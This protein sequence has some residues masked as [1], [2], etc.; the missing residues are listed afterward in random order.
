MFRTLRK[1]RR[2]VAVTAAA[3][4]G[5]TV[6]TAAAARGPAA[7]PGAVTTATV[8][9]VV[10][11]GLVAGQGGQISQTFGIPN[12]LES[13]GSFV[14]V[15]PKRFNAVPHV[16]LGTST[17]PKNGQ[18]AAIQATDVNALAKVPILGDQAALSS[19]S[20]LL[21][22]VGLSGDYSATPSVTHTTTTLDSG[23]TKTAYP[24]DTV[25]TYRLAL[26]GLPVTGQGGKLRVT[27]AGDGSVTELTATPRAVRPAGTVSVISVDAA[28]A[29]CAA[30]YGP[31]V[32]QD[33]PTLGYDFPALTAVRGGGQ[34]TVRNLF[35]Q[36]TCNPIGQQGAQAGRLIPAVA[37]SAPQGT[38]TASR[39]GTAVT[40]SV[41]GVSGGVGPYT[42][43]WSSSTTAIPSSANGGTTLSYTRA[44]R[45]AATDERVT[46]QI[47]DTD[48]LS[49]TA[50]VDLPGDGTVGA[51][52]IP[53][54]GGLT[55]LAWPNAGIEQTVDEWN[56]AQDSADGFHNVMAAHGT[57]V[58]F[59]WRGVNAWEDEFEEPAYGG[60]DY[61]WIDS[62]DIGWYTGHGWPGG[63]TFK[64]SVDETSITPAE[65]QWGDTALNWMQLES[66]N[67]LQ[68]T[69]GFNNY[70]DR[71]LPTMDG[72]HILNGF[73]THAY[74]VGGGTGADFAAYLFPRP[75]LFWTQ[76]ALPIVSA[77]AQMAIDKEP[78]GVVWRSMGPTRASDGADDW[79]DYYWGQGPVGPSIFL[80]DSG[81][82]GWG[83]AESG[84][85]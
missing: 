77:W 85:V 30:L 16:S 65:I 68:D 26:G 22:A 71:W 50:T 33:A 73:D 7:P 70:F 47:T 51:K 38:M 12:A 63:F 72:L 14:F 81:N 66:C 59:D 52:T 27:F 8:Y 21:R 15:D 82:G 4:L 18:P 53:G 55:V 78:S 41:G 62:V 19:A 76:P 60:D 39:S 64:S 11:E 34:G 10:Q 1:P 36:Y 46:L 17:D 31:T 74:C 24:L 40:A 79:G 25:V 84:T 45:A 43:K 3:C 37:G 56:C 5:L 58:A 83:W 6:P 23:G 29:A 80:G 69:N 32:K 54:G 35:P 2:A 28:A 13:D 49:A 67:V 48:G 20:R 61:N 9:Q 44:P 42:Y 57:N 75:Y